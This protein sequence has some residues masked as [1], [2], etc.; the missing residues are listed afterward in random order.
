M[1]I[2]KI[3]TGQ[4]GERPLSRVRLFIEERNETVLENLI[5]RYSR[6]SKA[7]RKEVLPKVFKKLGIDVSASWSQ[8]AGCSCGCSPGFILDI[9]PGSCGYEVIWVTIK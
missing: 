4:Y 2:V 1:K 5:L 3:K 9:H 8:K 6:P 7:Y